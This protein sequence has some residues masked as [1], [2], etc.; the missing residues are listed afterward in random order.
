MISNVGFADL[1]SSVLKQVLG[2]FSRFAVLEERLIFGSNGF[3]GQ[4]RL[5]CVLR[6]GSPKISTIFVTWDVQVPKLLC[7]RVAQRDNGKQAVKKK[8]RERVA[9]EGENVPP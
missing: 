5:C 7:P 1:F 8:E 2:E 3:P 4:D 6:D 9:R